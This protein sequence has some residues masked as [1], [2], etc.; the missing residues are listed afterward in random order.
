MP[1]PNDVVATLAECAK[2]NLIGARDVWFGRLSL[3]TWA[4]F[5]GL[6]LELPELIYGIKEIARERIPFFKYRIVLIESRVQLAKTVA[7][8]GWFFIVGGVG[9]ELAAGTKIDDL[10]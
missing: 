1:L 4:V 7:F 9:G 10:S 6:L 5:W 2:T 8:V 3:S